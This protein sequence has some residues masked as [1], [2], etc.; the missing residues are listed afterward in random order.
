MPMLLLT[1][2]SDVHCWHV[3][4]QIFV[5]S[6]A[7]VSFLVIAHDSAA[8]GEQEDFSGTAFKPVAIKRM[9]AGVVPA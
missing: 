3:L 5:Q 6:I 1:H 2:L 8:N 4:I 7:G 9:K